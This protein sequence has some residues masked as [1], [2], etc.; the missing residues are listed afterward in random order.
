M[1]STAWSKTP[2]F[3]HPGDVTG[4]KTVW[5]EKTR[6]FAVRNIKTSRS[7]ILRLFSTAC[8]LDQYKCSSGGCVNQNQRCDGIDHCPDRSDEWN[9]IKIDNENDTTSEEAQKIKKMFLQVRPSK[10][11]NFHVI[12]M[13]SSG[14]FERKEVELHLLRGMELK[15]F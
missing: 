13:R 4:S 10:I 5:E 11:S 15:S 12:P 2:V 1:N 14:L 6:S 8:S 7:S 9:C 3:L